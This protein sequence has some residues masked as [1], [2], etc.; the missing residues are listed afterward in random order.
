MGDGTT[1]RV[2]RDRWI[3]Q[4]S[5]FRTITL[6][7]TLYI[8]ST[9]SELIDEVTGKWKAALIKQIF[10]PTEAQTILGIPRSHR[11]TND[12]MVWAYTPKGNFMVNSAYKVAIAISP[13]TTTK[14]A[15][16]NDMKGQFWWKLWSLDIPKKL[17]TFAWK[18][19]HNI[20]PMKVNPCRRG[21]IDNATCET[22]GWAEETSGH[23]FWDCTKAHEVW[24]ATGISFDARGISFREFIDFL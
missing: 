19:S 24:L 10:L 1:T 21:V 11:R 12:R 14:S 5:T 6:P 23:L 17:K 2:W 4:P 8:D 18:A 22:C 16:T 9:V 7:N 15:L 13:N 3:P 20:L